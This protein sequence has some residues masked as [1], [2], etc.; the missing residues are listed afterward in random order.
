M[1]Y[2]YT[3]VY[4]IVMVP[5]CFCYDARIPRHSGAGPAPVSN[6][7]F[8]YTPAPEVTR[9]YAEAN[10]CGMVHNLAFPTKFDGVQGMGCNRPWGWCRRDV[11]QCTG[12]WGHTWP[13]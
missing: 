2:G 10:G 8:F 9:A 11:I 7:Y 5:F 3:I 6:D 1:L 4:T 12:V 13:M